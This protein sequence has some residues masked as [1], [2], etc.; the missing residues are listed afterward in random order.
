M[1]DIRKDCLKAIKAM[2]PPGPKGDRPTRQMF[3]IKK[4]NKKK[5]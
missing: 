5:K 1:S 2:I 4:D 3:I